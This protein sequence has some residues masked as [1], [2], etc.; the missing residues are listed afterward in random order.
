MND[1]EL[2]AL[3]WI[4]IV[5]VWALS[6]RD[7]RH[8]LR[9][10]LATAV[11]PALS[12]PL[13][14]LV[15]WVGGLI[16]IAARLGIWEA[17]LISDAVVWFIGT[18]LVLFGRAIDVFKPNG[19]F[20]RVVVTSLGLTVLVEGFVN[21]Y[22]F[23][24]W[25]EFL[26]FPLV[27][28]ATALLAA[29]EGMKHE[30]VAN[31]LTWVLASVGLI[32]GLYVA[33]RLGTDFD[34][35]VAGTGPKELLLPIWLTAGTLPFVAVLGA[36][37]VYDTAYRHIKWAAQENRRATWSGMLALVSGLHVHVRQVAG[38]NGPWAKRV[39]GASSLSGARAA[40][41]HFRK[42]GPPDGPALV[43]S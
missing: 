28:T 15:G 43:P 23:P 14:A 31:L 32:L 16:W 41:S 38:F 40:V 7:F 17:A 10:I 24:F 3:I 5:L 29:A 37:S 25:V 12:V 13:L 9:G 35:F 33:V 8:G 19:S 34:S 22:V 39:V 11:Q 20:R 1:R 42:E 27:V 18:G 2:A 21:L 6:L 36:Y 30:A 26:L 4:G